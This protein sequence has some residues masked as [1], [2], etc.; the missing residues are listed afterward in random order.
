MTVHSHS[1]SLNPLVVLQ[2]SKF[3][4]CLHQGPVTPQ[5]YRP[6]GQVSLTHENGY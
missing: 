4:L 3:Q 2:A 5:V 6:A 1:I